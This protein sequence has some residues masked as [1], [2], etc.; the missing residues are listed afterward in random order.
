MILVS[1][2]TYLLG[3]ITKDTEIG[4][5]CRVAL[6]SGHVDLANVR[7]RL[8]HTQLDIKDLS[9]HQMVCLRLDAAC[10]VLIYEKCPGLLIGLP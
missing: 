4:Q 2:C 8:Q 6:R 5:S 7:Q 3:K 10:V 9:V 1:V